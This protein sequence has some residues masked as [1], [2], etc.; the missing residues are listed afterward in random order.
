MT[1][2]T[3]PKVPR[4]E[5]KEVDFTLK[6]AEVPTEPDTVTVT[7]KAPDGSTIETDTLAGGGVYRPPGSSASS[8]P[9]HFRAKRTVGTSEALSAAYTVYVAWTK[10]SASSGSLYLASY[11]VVASSQSVVQGGPTLA[12]P[13]DV[14]DALFKAGGFNET[15]APSDPIIQDRL[16][17]KQEV[18]LA[19]A[20]AD[21]L[22][23]LTPQQ[24]VVAKDVLIALVVGDLLAS[25]YPNSADAAKVVKE[26]RARALE[27]L[28]AARARTT[29]TAK[30]GFSLGVV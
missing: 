30:R 2:Y 20:G 27:D 28:E 6:L 21:D 10:G 24:Q 8:D 12:S 7:W 17:R 16:T 11:E 4:G 1:V 13:Q 18:V 9:G 14:K 3:G 19:H 23:Q 5:E 29:K 22:T 15:D 25:Y 26:W